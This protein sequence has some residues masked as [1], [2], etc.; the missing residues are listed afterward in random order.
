MKYED[1]GYR[2]PF[3]LKYDFEKEE[4]FFKWNYRNPI[5][6]RDVMFEETISFIDYYQANYEKIFQKYTT[7]TDEE[8]SYLYNLCDT[9]E[10]AEK[11]YSLKFHL[12]NRKELEESGMNIPLYIDQVRH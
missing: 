6:F 1:I 7:Y 8:A 10:D 9:K 11:I 4:G 12:K 2:A 3:N 5:H